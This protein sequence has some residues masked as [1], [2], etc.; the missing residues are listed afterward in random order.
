MKLNL[1]YIVI[2]WKANVIISEIKRTKLTPQF[3]FNIRRYRI[4]KLDQYSVTRNYLI[5]I[6]R[7]L[8]HFIIR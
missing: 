7:V 5:I 8:S 4:R 6:Y 1:F 3:F 2:C